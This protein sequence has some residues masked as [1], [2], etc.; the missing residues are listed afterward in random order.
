MYNLKNKPIV[1]GI[2]ISYQPS[3][4]DLY[5]SIKNLTKEV[6]IIILVENGS[7]KYTQ[8]KI[9]DIVKDNK[10]DLL[11]QDTNQGLG[12]A[13]NIGIQHGLKKKAKY[14]LFLDDDSIL[15]KG[16]T[17]QLI[18]EL[19]SNPNL[20]LAACNIIHKDSNKI[21]KYW[22]KTKFFYKRISFSEKE[23][24]FQNVN[25]VI[26]SG[27]MIPRKVIEQCG[28]FREDYFIDYIDIEYN[29]RIRSN[30]YTITVIRNAELLH[31]LGNTKSIQ[32][33]RLL[34]IHPT[35]HNPSRRFFMIRNRIWTWKIYM[36]TFPGWFLIDF[37]NFIFDNMRVLLFE[38]NKLENLIQIFRGIKAGFSKIEKN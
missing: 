1:A 38:N 24:K 2:I 7:D 35:F 4:D 12:F 9:K 30:G 26:S 37:S 16:S 36:L 32:I 34:E 5:L 6:D 23:E 28:L 8:N 27:S 15:T 19:E 29:L 25:T 13:Q 18:L 11:I 22:I 17:K 21:Q 10:I 33:R 31:K 20:G 14:F 3:I